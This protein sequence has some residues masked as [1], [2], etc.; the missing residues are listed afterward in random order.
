[1]NKKDIVEII[2]RRQ[3]Q[4]KASQIDPLKSKLSEVRDESR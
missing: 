1:M 3:E 2:N 4:R